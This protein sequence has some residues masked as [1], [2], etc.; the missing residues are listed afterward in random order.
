MEDFLCLKINEYIKRGVNPPLYY[1]LDQLYI[2]NIE[3]Y[4]KGDFY[5][6]DGLMIV[7]I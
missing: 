5:I 4:K 7:P 3:Y 1:F 2:I 6:W